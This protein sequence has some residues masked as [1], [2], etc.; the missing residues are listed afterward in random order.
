MKS[1][2]LLT[3]IRTM[4]EKGI[5]HPND[6]YI[7]LLMA[8]T[9]LDQGDSVVFS[10][11]ELSRATGLSRSS[12]FRSIKRMRTQCLCDTQS[13]RLTPRYSVR[14]TLSVRETLAETAKNPRSHDNSAS[15]AKAHAECPND[16]VAPF[17]PHTPLNPKRNNIYSTYSSSR[18]EDVRDTENITLGREVTPTSTESSNATVESKPKKPKPEAKKFGEF[19][20]MTD[21]EFKMLTDRFGEGP[22]REMIETLD[23]YKGSSGRRYKSDYRAILSWVVQRYEEDCARNHRPIPYKQKAERR[24]DNPH[25][26]FEGGGI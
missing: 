4:Q 7:W 13:V 5:L 1:G 9:E 15:N 18:K 20:S 3:E 21:A 12:V 16:T 23:N 26:F 14:G 11:D 25:D 19:V 10:P 2:Y 24:Y 8:M 17:S 6:V 22:A